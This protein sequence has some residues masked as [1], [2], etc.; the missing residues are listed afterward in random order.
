MQSLSSE[1]T[2]KNFCSVRR[3]EHGSRS[4]SRSG[5][6]SRKGG[7]VGGAAGQLVLVCYFPKLGEGGRG[8][9]GALSVTEQSV[10]CVS[11][12]AWR[13]LLVKRGLKKGSHCNTLSTMHCNT[14]RNNATH[15][16]TMQHTATHCN[17]MQHNPTHCNTLQHTATHCNSGL[18]CV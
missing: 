18:S 14:P 5:S 6:S 2:S 17:I 13:I 15:C 1:L 11:F 3:R 4:R 12:C 7:G 10:S 9:T 8:G 16:K